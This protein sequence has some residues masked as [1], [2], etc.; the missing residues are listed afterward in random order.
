MTDEKPIEKTE[1]EPDWV[2]EM[3]RIM[4]ASFW[5]AELAAI[6]EVELATKDI[7]DRQP[8]RVYDPRRARPI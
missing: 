4:D 3:N 1:G 2:Q 6:K 8:K 5:K 7:L